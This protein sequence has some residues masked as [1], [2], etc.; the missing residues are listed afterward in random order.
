MKSAPPLLGPTLALAAT[1]LAG[2]TE[3]EISYPAIDGGADAGGF[4]CL[5]NL[6][7]QLDVSE[8]QAVIGVPVTYLVSA[9]VTTPAVDLVGTVDAAGNTI[10][11]FSESVSSDVSV[12]ISAQELNGKWY[13]ASFPAGQWVAPIDV[14]DTV[15]GVYSADS[16][17]IYLQG[18]ASTVEAPKVGKTLLVYA[19]PVALYRFP[20][21][22]GSAFTS[23]G[24]VTGGTL[25]GLPYSGTDTYAVADDAI[26]Q[27]SLHDYLFTQVH[28]VRTT[29]V[30]TPS[31]GEAQVTRQVSFLFECFGEIVRATSKVG[32]TNDNFT[33]A[34]EL[35][36]LDD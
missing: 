17:A 6:D 25:R 7:G 9:P 23:I 10:W 5:P 28:R 13:Q 34:A 30:V 2:C 22:P 11:D 21:L 33:T 32:E 19:E 31:A 18:L 14:G 29:A 26:G 16:Q 1:L 36:R 8:L 20:L 3:P 27:V 35:R 4:T 15:E 24:T 12:T